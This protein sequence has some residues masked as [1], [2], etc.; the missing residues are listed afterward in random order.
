[1]EESKM[2]QDVTLKKLRAIF[3][4][5]IYE[6]KIWTALLSK[7]V[8]SAGE[9]ADISGVPRSRSYDVLESLEKRGFVM[10]KLGKPIKYMALKPE[11]VIKRVKKN[12]YER[13]VE[14]VQELDKVKGTDVY[15]EL[16]LLFKQ[17]IEKVDPTDTSG[18]LKGRKNVHDHLKALIGE[19]EKSLTI[20]TTAQ[21]LFRKADALKG[22]LKR[23]KE[24]G[25]SVR[26]AAPIENVN[27]LPKEIKNVAEIRKY[28]GP[29]SRFVLVDG[30]EVVFM[31]SDDKDVHEA[32]DNA[33]WVR[34]P[35]F[36]S[37]FEQMFDNTWQK[38]EKV[39]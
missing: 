5:N 39:N 16:T 23:A 15:N 29:N 10:M 38:M 22:A 34:S 33:V 20:V 17:G 7:G 30:K 2:M 13:A 37:A 21:G 32:Y 27:L 36:A 3:D 6:V 28:D 18:L 24:R 11:E 1:M 31:T 9:L 4:L 14:H 19:A 25:V 12:I 26:I 8:A 35:F